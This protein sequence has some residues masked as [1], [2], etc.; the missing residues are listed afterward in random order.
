M[1]QGFCGVAELVLEFDEDFEA[2]GFAVAGPVFD[3]GKDG[4]DAHG[5]GAEEGGVGRGFEVEEGLAAGGGEEHDR[6]RE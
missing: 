2:V 1:P 3:L 6:D 5:G 4:M